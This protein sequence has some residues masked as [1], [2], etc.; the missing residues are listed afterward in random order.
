M[1]YELLLTDAGKAILSGDGDV[2]WSSDG[3]AEFAEEFDG[4]MLDSGELED[5]AAWLVD[6]GY[7]PPGVELDLIDESIEESEDSGWFRNLSEN[8]TADDT[9]NG[10]E[11]D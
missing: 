10:K 11:S 8:E 6:A 1:N 3:D 9:N 5:V 4:E 2:L 7:L